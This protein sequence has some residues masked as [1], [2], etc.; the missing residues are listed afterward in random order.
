MNLFKRL[1][2]IVI[3][4]AVSLAMTGCYDVIYL[5]NDNASSTAEPISPY[6]ENVKKIN[7][8]VVCYF[9]YSEPDDSDGQQFLVAETHSID[10]SSGNYEKQLLNELVKGPTQKGKRIVSLIPKGTTFIVNT[11]EQERFVSVT[12]SSTFFTA[13]TNFPSDWSS[14][15]DYIEKYNMQKRLAIYSIVDTL[16][17]SG[18]Y[19]RVQIL[20]DYDGSGFGE[21][22]TRKEVGFTRGENSGELLETMYRTTE[23]ILTPENTIN[24][25]MY[26][27]KKDSL[28]NLYELI[29]LVDL[30][31]VKKPTQEEVIKT[32]E[33]LDVTV[34][35]YNSTNSVVS[36]D[37][38]T[39]TLI[40]N[41]D[42]QIGAGTNKETKYF[43]NL[44]I[45][46]V[47]EDGIWKIQYSDLIENL[48]N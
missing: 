2:C 31:G 35:S 43:K 40:L 39:A 42:L 8:N 15:S 26:Y 3:L 23:V 28:E 46:L 47:K 24:T 4:A 22:P 7:S 25:I 16:T 11:K 18:K 20:I 33:D 17:E 12:I 5:S 13:P 29:M 38:T 36:P 27:L 1:T 32:L 14:R 45:R 37:G 44:T 30:D 19:D 48:T 21:I 6:N 41:A 34:T 10:Y 9:G